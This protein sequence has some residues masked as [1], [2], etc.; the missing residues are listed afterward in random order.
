MFD[1]PEIDLGEWDGFV[2]TD[3]PVAN[4]DV[5]EEYCNA[6]EW[7]V[8]GFLPIGGSLYI[9]Q[10]W[11]AKKK[12][13]TRHWF[14][15]EAARRGQEIIA[16]CMCGQGDFSCIHQRYFRKCISPNQEGE[17]NV[18]ERLARIVLFHRESVSSGQVIHRFSVSKN[19]GTTSLHGRAIV[20]HEGRDDGDG[21]WRC[22]R[23]STQCIHIAAARRYLKNG[24]Q[25]IESD[26]E[27]EDMMEEI[28]GINL[29]CAISFQLVLPPKWCELKTDQLLYPRP[30]PL[31]QVPETLGMDREG[32]CACRD[33]SR[34]LY[35]KNLPTFLRK[36]TVYTLSRAAH[37]S[38]ELQRCTSCKRQYVGPETRHLGLFN[39]NNSLLFTHELLDEYTSAF[40]SSETPFNAWVQ[41]VSRRYQAEDN[42]IPFVGVDT[43]RAAWFAYARLINFEGDKQC[44]RCGEEPENVVWDGVTLA[45]ARKQLRAGLRPPTTVDSDSPVRPRTVAKRKE[46]LE[47]SVARKRLHHWIAKGGMSWGNDE[48]ER[49]PAEERQREYPGIVE[50]LQCVNKHLAFLFE[51]YLGNKAMERNGKWKPQREYKAFFEMVRS[52]KS[53]RIAELTL[54]TITD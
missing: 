39:L 8:V 18:P 52:F 24:I 7:N 48:K 5:D 53:I 16:V 46:W 32:A 34:R 9:V 13:G 11:S 47:D 3:N 44:Q 49:G 31:R 51:E 23:D 54:T 35:D 1:P 29:N 40:T 41:Q 33:G 27:L 26:E 22:L 21:L 38:I 43:F 14:H 15:F 6:V 19:G 28:E 36:C 17:E 2:D 12:E 25:E 10:G 4:D 42:S 50:S 30:P 37:T 20:I 45:Y